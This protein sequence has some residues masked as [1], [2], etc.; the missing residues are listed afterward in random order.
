MNP[1]I[2]MSGIRPTGTGAAHLGHWEGALKNWLKL[3]DMGE[4]YYSI[5]DWHALTT[6][7]QDVKNIQSSVRQILLDLLAVGIDPEKSV[8]Y[9]QS[10]V[11]EISELFLLLGMMTPL[12][13]LERVPTFKEQQAQLGDRDINTFGFLGYPLLQTV[14]II[15]MKADTVP[16]GED[17]VYHLE[18]AREIVRRFNNLY[19][20]C[21]P[22]PQPFL[23][24][25]PK[26]PGV[27]GRKMSKSYGNAIYLNDST[28]VLEEKIRPMVTDVRRKRRSDPGLPEDCPVF[29]L[30]QAY[31]NS[32]EIAMVSA[33]CRTAGIG[34]LDCKKILIRNI[35][36]FLEPFRQRRSSYEK[37][38]VADILEPGNRRA[39]EQARRT[40]SQ[41]REL[42]NV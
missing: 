19:G 8:I 25:I 24:S 13:W 42:M 34:C 7:Y 39:V 40:V 3:Q 38:A 27:D 23:T 16:V 4:C 33:E 32:E 17:Q 12:G 22:E 35:N 14:D 20:D 29:T 9:L 41:V 5:V 37:I 11:K 30:H 31:S 2:I 28:A 6:E 1:R 21:F 18:L 26:L 36:T 10:A 15:I